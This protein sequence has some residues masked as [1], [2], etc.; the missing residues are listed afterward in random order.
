M[1]SKSIKIYQIGIKS[2]LVYGNLW[3]LPKLYALWAYFDIWNFFQTFYTQIMLKIAF[4]IFKYHLLRIFIFHIFGTSL[5]EMVLL[6]QQLVC[7]ILGV[8]SK[9]C[10]KQFLIFLIF[11]DFTVR[12][13]CSVSKNGPNLAFEF[14]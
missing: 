10:W 7:C 2:A 5:S 9:T 11:C 1:P 13:G 14:P 8:V 4:G 6:S 3:Y 12:Y